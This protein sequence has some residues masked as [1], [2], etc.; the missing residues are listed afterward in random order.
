MKFKLTNEKQGIN[1]WLVCILLWT[2]TIITL[3]FISAV[4]PVTTTQQFTEGYNIQIPQDNI[5]KLGQNY[6]FEFH[7]T[8]I[9]NGFPITS[10]INCSFHLYDEE[11]NHIF[12][13]YDDTA[14][15][16]YDYS[17]F[18]LGNNFSKIG[19]Y[20]YFT[21][22]NSSSLG[23]FGDSVLYINSSGLTGTLGLFVIAFLLF[24]G[25]TF[26][27]IRIKNIWVSLIG[28]FGLLLLGLYTS[29]N[30]IDIYKNELTSAVSYVTIAI[31]LGMG[32]QALMEITD[33]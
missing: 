10:G 28:T 22:C 32:F 33:L 24:F 7:V 25:L 14:S 4:P 3:S 29:F 16:T 23:G 1:F 11:G 2:I 26:Y 20:Y 30:G 12:Q 27:G 19:A 21:Q 17:F 15:S 6:T 13:G 9:S 5:L 31:G 8:N 18:I